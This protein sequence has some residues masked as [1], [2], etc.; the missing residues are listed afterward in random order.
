MHYIQQYSPFFD[1]KNTLNITIFFI[2]CINNTIYIKYF[3]S[4]VMKMHLKSLFS[5]TCI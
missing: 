3:A 1:L 4:F 2:I 5:I